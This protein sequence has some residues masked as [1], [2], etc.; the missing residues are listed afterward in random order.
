M[1]DESFNGAAD[2]HPRILVLRRPKLT[3]RQ[4]S[5]G[6]R[7]FIRGYQTPSRLGRRG[8]RL[9]WGRGFSSADTS[10]CVPLHQRCDASMG[11]RIFIRGYDRTWYRWYANDDA[12][13]GPRIFIRGYPNPNPN[14]NHNQRLQWGRGFSSADTRAAIGAPRGFGASMGPRIFIRGYSWPSNLFII[15]ELHRLFRA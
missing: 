5:M 4:A 2:F 15:K 7:I 9:Q 10:F 12:S 8:S 14:P 11:P 3:D 13:M 6:P 1:R